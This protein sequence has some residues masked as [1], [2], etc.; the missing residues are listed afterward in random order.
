MSLATLTA[1]MVATLTSRLYPVKV[2]SHG[3]AFTE[4][5]LALLLGDAPCLLVAPLQL[6]GFGPNHSLNG[7]QATA[8][9]TLYCLS[10]DAGG[11]RADAAMDHAQAVLNL[12]LEDQDWGLP[13]QCEPPLLTSLRA[14]NLYSG[15]INVLSVALW[16][17]SWD[18]PF[19]FTAS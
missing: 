15:K 6:S 14:E 18:Q 8:R 10:T 13:R 3:G 17:V 4:R 12:L 9:F 11:N 2:K 1:A 7:W 5:E 16:A 19:I